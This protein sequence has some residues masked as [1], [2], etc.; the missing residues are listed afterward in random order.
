[1]T[2][3]TEFHPSPKRPRTRKRAKRGAQARAA[4]STLDVVPETSANGDESNE[5]EVVVSLLG[6]GP[7]D[8]LPERGSRG[9]DVTFGVELTNSPIKLGPGGPAY[10]YGGGI[11]TSPS[12][13]RRG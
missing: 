6:G 9:V 12:K 4:Q 1:V 11:T 13:S 8:G 10:G 7:K 3:G 5:E 2:R